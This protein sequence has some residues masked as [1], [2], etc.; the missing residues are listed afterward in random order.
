MSFFNIGTGVGDAWEAP[1]ASTFVVDVDGTTIGHFTEVQ[2]LQ[3]EI[4]TE[5]IEEGGVNS[6][7]H[8]VPGRMKWPNITLKRGITDS[9]ALFQWME[10]SSGDGFTKNGDKVTRS[11]MG[12]TLLA[13]DGQALR[14]WSV[15]GALPIKWSGP[16]FAA[17]NDDIL[18]EELEIAHHGFRSES[19]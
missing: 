6:F 2:G 1:L 13:P 12:I 15:E 17:S 18:S 9:D 3:L 10:E 19:F 11:T 7:V 16:T 5:T 8:T 14:E 4:E